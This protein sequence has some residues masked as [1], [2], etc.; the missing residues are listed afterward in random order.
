MLRNIARKITAALLC[1]GLAIQ[2]AQAADEGV[3]RDAKPSQLPAQS[4]QGSPMP[5]NIQMP[6]TRPQ[7]NVAPNTVRE[8]ISPEA[9]ANFVSSMMAMNP[10][11]LQDMVAMMAVKYPAKDGLSYDDVVTAMKTKANEL[12]FK[13]VGHNPLWKDIVAISGKQDTPRVEFFT[14]C[15]AMVAREILDL[16]IEFAIF[17][18]CRVAVLEDANKKIWL[19]TLDWDVRWLDSSKNPNKMSA[20]LRE[21][22]IMVREAI[23][24][25]M[26]A[27][28]NGDF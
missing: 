17:L 8:S 9:R 25:I 23:D 15:D 26:R 28:A 21:K 12:N 24:K 7:E 10:F 20:S 22:S 4:L 16:S 2:F 19:M 27:G 11:S 13:F 14:F 6:P 1:A 18:P 5:F 3:K